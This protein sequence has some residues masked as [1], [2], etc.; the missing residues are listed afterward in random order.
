ML[1]SEPVAVRLSLVAIIVSLYC[2]YP[3]IWSVLLSWFSLEKKR[4]RGPIRVICHATFSIPWHVNWS[5]IPDESREHMPPDQYER[6]VT[7]NSTWKLMVNL[8]QVSSIWQIANIF[9][10]HWFQYEEGSVPSTHKVSFNCEWIIRNLVYDIQNILPH[11]TDW[12]IRKIPHSADQDVNDLAKRAA[13]DGL[14][15][16]N[17]SSQFQSLSLDLIRKKTLRCCPRMA[18]DSMKYDPTGKKK[19]QAFFANVLFCIS[20]NF[21]WSREGFFKAVNERGEGS[22]P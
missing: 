10:L 21:L 12:E 7:A 15:S 4:S 6:I 16:R 11:F 5:Q 1:Y 3:L 18:F 17:T 2:T 9:Q 14:L 22:K 8:S 13:E 19:T 20:I